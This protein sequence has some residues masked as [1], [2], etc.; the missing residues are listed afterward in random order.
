[1]K[2]H[3]SVIFYKVILYSVSK[4]LYGIVVRVPDFGPKG[5]RFETRAWRI[6]H[7]LRKVPEYYTQFHLYLGILSARPSSSHYCSLGEL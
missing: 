2:F 4:Q 6:F 1:M 7:E 5:P 3:T